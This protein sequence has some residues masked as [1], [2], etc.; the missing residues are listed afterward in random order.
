MHLQKLEEKLGYT[1]RNKKLLEEAV[2]HRSYKQEIRSGPVVHNERLEFLGDAVLELIV[3]DYLYHRFQE[4][5]EGELTQM[6]AFLVG[7]A[8]ATEV[9]MALGVNDFLLLGRGEEKSEKS[10]QFILANAF[11]AIIGAIYLDGGLE[12]ATTFVYTILL[13]KTGKDVLREDLR[14]P[15]SKLQEVVQSLPIKA[16][17]RY[18]TFSTSGPDHNKTFAVGVYVGD[19]LQGK[20]EGASILKAQNAAALEALKQYE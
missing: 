10:R 8:K 13:V 7:G 19:E 17:P 2:T 14:D 1:F 12:S 3:T 18:V 4:K 11:E 15:K 16:T 9:S 5:T 6:R 20:G